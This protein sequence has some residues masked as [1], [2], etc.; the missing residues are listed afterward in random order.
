MYKSL[1]FTNNTDTAYYIQAD[2]YSLYFLCGSWKPAVCSGEPAVRFSMRMPRRGREVCMIYLDNGATSFPKP[3]EMVDAMAEAMTG[4]C[5][6]PGRSG[7]SMAV[8]TAGEISKVRQE[9]ARLIGTEK[10]ER[11]IFTKNCTEGLNLALKGLLREGD[12][13]I[14]SS[15]EHNSV[16]RPLKS[17]ERKGVRVSVVGCAADGNL[18]TEDIRRALRP[19]TKL[20]VVTAASNVTGT[21]MPLE[22]IG[23]IALRNGIVFLV[24][25]AQGLGHMDIDVKRQHIGMLAAPGHKGLLGPQ[26]TGLLYVREGLALKPLNEGGTGSRSRDMVQPLDFPDGYEAGTLNAPGII[27]L[28]AALR[29]LNK[30]GVAAVEDYECMLNGLLQAELEDIAVFSQGRNRSGTAEHVYQAGAGRYGADMENDRWQPIEQDTSV[31]GRSITHASEQTGVESAPVILYGPAD[32][33]DRT[34]ITAL[35][36]RGIDC[37]EAAAIL[38][39]R[40][41]IAV[42]AGF[43]CSGIAHDTIGTGE[44]GCIRICPGIYNTEQDIRN[45]AKA[46]REIAQQV[47]GR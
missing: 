24:D 33:A 3:G 14:T 12:H 1:F 28:G 45:T 13:V 2:I 8:K 15:M 30:V 39:D 42:R 22:K 44:T 47:A 21:K 6:N 4:Y 31:D 9:I 43:H 23:R 17:L 20:I 40:Y 32:P 26:G 27:G 35:N 41:G 5:A 34:G 7:H 29:F 18:D 10:P 25:G 11:I 46:I 19:D 37:E 36:I 16:M 38:N